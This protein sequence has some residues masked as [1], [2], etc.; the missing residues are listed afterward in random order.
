[1]YRVLRGRLT[2]RQVMAFPGKRRTTAGDVRKVAL[3]ALNTALDDGK[4]AAQSKPRL[5]GVR[6]VAGGAVLYTVGR[7]VVTRGRFIRNP[8]GEQGAEGDVRDEEVMEE[9]FEE[10]A[11]EEDEEF[12][13]P[14]G[15]EDEESE[16]E[17]YE[18]PAA[19]ED[20]EPVGEEDE[21]DEG[22]EDE[23][24]EEPVGEEDEEFEEEEEEYEEP[25]AEEDEELEDEEEEYEE[26][27][28]EED[29]E[30]EDEEEEYEEPAAE[31]DEEF[32]EEEEEYEV[33]SRPRKRSAASLRR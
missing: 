26:P 21:E 15:E 24:Y 10:P 13:E 17:E 18:E 29:E 27:A 5:V 25:A 28:A 12:E 31:E 6:A 33:S 32:E 3:A 22:Y 30:F 9:E 4:R 20:E 19:E 23:E 11:A 16:E 8:F 1:M 14:V 2:R 7:A